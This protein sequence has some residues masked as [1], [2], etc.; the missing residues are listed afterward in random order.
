MLIY[1]VKS[2]T[3]KDFSKE[4]QLS[5]S[6]IDFDSFYNTIYIQYECRKDNTY[7]EMQTL[8]PLYVHVV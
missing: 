8:F 1:F 4:I 7:D 5:V 3:I 2:S 6:K